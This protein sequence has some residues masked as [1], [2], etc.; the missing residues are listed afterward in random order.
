LPELLH[1]DANISDLRKI[2]SML[3]RLSFVPSP[4]GSELRKL[5]IRDEYPVTLQISF[6]ISADPRVKNERC[7]EKN[8]F[9]LISAGV[10]DQ[11]GN[12]NL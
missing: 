9:N 10:G 5:Q 6:T 12:R 11:V 8:R 7:G 4:S 3:N 2:H 1:G